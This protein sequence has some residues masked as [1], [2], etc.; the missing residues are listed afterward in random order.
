[1]MSFY[2]SVNI[3]TKTF[4]R[5][6]LVTG[7]V[8]VAHL[9][10]G[11]K[12]CPQKLEEAE[13]L[14]DMGQIN[15]VEALVNPCLEEGFSKGEKVRAYRLLTLCNLYY[16]EDE[17]AKE[18]MEKLLKVDPEYKIKEFDPSEFRTLH[19]A[20]RTIPVF[21][22]GIKASVGGMGLYD[23][24]NYNDINSTGYSATYKPDISYSAGICFET[25]IFQEFS[26][27]YEF[28]YSAYSYSF[29]N[30]PLD[31][32]EISYKETVSGIDVPVLLQWN[33]LEGNFVPYVNAGSSFNMLLSSQASF[34]RRDYEGDQYREPVTSDID[35]TDSRNKYNF[36]I[37]AGVGFRWKNFLG[38]GYLTFDIRYTRYMKTLV[39]PENRAENPEMMYSYLTTDNVFKIQ[40][41][42]FLVGYKIPI[43]IATHKGR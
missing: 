43:Y 1:M 26:V 10:F 18:A 14:Y 34:Y 6:L 27:V 40:N 36:S 29:E 22:T 7:F 30:K 32:A 39:N 24:T 13:E 37:A 31:Y 41:T 4:N 11:Q 2:F 17:K 35:L 33:I 38:R 3:F 20:F 5:F 42:Q 21:I 23:I 16:N 12:S 15:R 9:S 8:L 25:P 19:K 28:Y